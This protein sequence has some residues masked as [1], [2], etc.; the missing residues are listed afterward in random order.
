MDQ[1]CILATI[2]TTRAN[3][4]IHDNILKSS[5]SETGDDN[6]LKSSSSI[7]CQ[8]FSTGGPLL[9]PGIV[10]NGSQSLF[11]LYEN[12]ND[13]CRKY[14]NSSASFEMETVEW[15]GFPCS[16]AK[17]TGSSWKETETET[18]A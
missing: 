5:S 4:R 9:G 7:I 11:V 8:C 14:I 16:I 6:I 2:K 18:D 10:L 3:E 13:L 17:R 12:L 15:L 1:E